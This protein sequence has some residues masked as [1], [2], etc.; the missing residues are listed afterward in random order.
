M[1]ASWWVNKYYPCF[2]EDTGH[3]PTSPPLH[4]PEE[5]QERRPGPATH[6]SAYAGQ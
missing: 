2:A 1:P 6:A 5:L 3:F 4:P